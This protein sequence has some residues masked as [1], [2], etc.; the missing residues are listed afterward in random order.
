MTR[1]VLA[2]IATAA[3]VGAGAR[4][5][6]GVGCRWRFYPSSLWSS[7]AVFIYL[8]AIYACAAF[9][10]DTKECFRPGGSYVI[11]FAFT[12]RGQCSTRDCAPQSFPCPPARMESGAK[13]DAIAAS[14]GVP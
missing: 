3:H 5:S 11:K 6:G 2:E 8:A 4:V 9:H 7:T 12:N 13:P 1:N 14:R 10:Q